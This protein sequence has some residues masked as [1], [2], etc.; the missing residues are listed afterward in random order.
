V[1]NPVRLLYAGQII[2]IKGVHT[3]IEAVRILVKEQGYSDLTFTIV[4][5]SRD[6]EYLDSLKNTVT[7]RDLEKNIRFRGFIPHEK[8]LSEYQNHDILVFPSI[9]DEPFGI[10]L[11][12]AMS[13]GLGVIT[14]ATG[15]SA[16]IVT[17][18][19]TT[20]LLFPRE[21]AKACASQIRRF[22]ENPRLLEKIRQSGRKRVEKKFTIDRTIELIEGSLFFAI[23][24]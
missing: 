5:G 14:T 11:L 7:T 16:E 17:A 23:S 8:I 15:G 19:E 13:C 4:G 10:T 3:V 6:S 21:D 2:P 9:W 20:A 18:D 12:E 1:H 22:L 24:S